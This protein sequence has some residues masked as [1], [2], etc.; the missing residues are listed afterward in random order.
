MGY[1]ILIFVGLIILVFY[2]SEPVPYC[3]L[4]EEQEPISLEEVTKYTEE[5]IFEIKDLNV[6]FLN[7]RG[8]SML[9]A[10]QDNSKCLCI[11]KENYMVGDII[12]FFA[13]IN[14][15]WNAVSHRIFSIEGNNVFTKGD[16]NDWIDPPMP[17]ENII[18]YIPYISRYKALF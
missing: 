15:E 10:I 18:C 5:Q 12:L 16:N 17:K 4:S 9:P 13:K 8:S 2:L 3:K 14:G 1:K 11:K 6:T 7:V